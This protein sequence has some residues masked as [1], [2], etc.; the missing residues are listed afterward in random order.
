MKAICRLTSKRIPTRV[1][2]PAYDANSVVASHTIFGALFNCAVKAELSRLIESLRRGDLLVSSLFPG[3]GKS[4]F[5]PKPLLVPHGLGLDKL[6]KFKKLKFVEINE[7]SEW[8]PDG[9][10][11]SLEKVPEGYKPLDVEGIRVTMDRLTNSTEP[12][13][14]ESYT[15]FKEDFAYFFI[16]FPDEL[17]EDVKSLLG[18]LVCEGIGGDRTVGYG[19]FEEFELIP[20][21]FENSDYYVSLSQFIPGDGERDKLVSWEI[22]EHGG[23]YIYKEGGT[24]L[25]KPLYRL[26]K[27]GSVLSEK[28]RGEVRTYSVPG[29]KE[30]FLFYA[31]AYLLPIGGKVWIG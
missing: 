28:A 27:E 24:T 12:F 17:E 21:R 26:C 10:K 11:I 13:V 14:D 9:I 16:D 15:F 31:K 25:I 18:L 22:V 8:K 3:K 30:E 2:K 5:V 19:I 23:T 20:V 6:K 7:L 1:R 29:H 4:F